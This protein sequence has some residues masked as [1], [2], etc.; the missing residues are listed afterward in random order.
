MLALPSINTPSRPSPPPSTPPSPGTMAPR[1]GIRGTVIP[2]GVTVAPFDMAAAAAAVAAAAASGGGGGGAD[3]A[4][5]GMGNAGMG[6]VA[7]LL[8]PPPTGITDGGNGGFWL[9]SVTGVP[10]PTEIDAS[11]PPPEGIKVGGRK[12]DDDGGV[13][14]DGYAE[15]GE[16]IGEHDGVVGGT[17]WLPPLSPSLSPS[18]TI[19]W[20]GC[21]EFCLP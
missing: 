2:V 21:C 12:T 13:A 14:A 15:E 16:R 20:D 4:S 17:S 18:V 19:M 3:S 10:P 11:R 7:K 9:F 8:L 6:L 5:S 1:D